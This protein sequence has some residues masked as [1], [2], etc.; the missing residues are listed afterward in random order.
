MVGNIVQAHNITSVGVSFP[1]SGFH[2]GAAKVF[3]STTTTLPFPTS[4]MLTVRPPRAIGGGFHFPNGVVQFSLLMDGKPLIN[5]T[6]SEN[7]FD[8]IHTQPFIEA[9]YVSAGTHSF[10][11]RFESTTADL[12]TMKTI[13]GAQ[14]K[15]TRP[16]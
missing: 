15:L 12:I 6:V 9:G 4:G 16:W 2:G 7:F 8:I 11:I 3:E 13:F 1:L 14:L 5:D 10:T